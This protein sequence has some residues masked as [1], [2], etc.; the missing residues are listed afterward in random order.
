[1]LCEE[2]CMSDRILQ[3]WEVLDRRELLDRR[4]WMRLWDEDVRL[5]DGR[6]IERFSRIEMPDYVVVVAVTPAG[7]VLTERSY[8]HGPR[9]VCITLPTGYVEQG[10]DPA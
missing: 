5:P 2:V 3:H 1:M 6:V 8:K 7:Q 10:R 4:P 9:R